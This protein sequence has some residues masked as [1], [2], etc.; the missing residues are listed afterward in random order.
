MNKRTLFG[1]TVG[2]SFSA[3]AIAGWRLYQQ[4]PIERVPSQEGIEDPAAAL[5]YGRIMRFPHVALLRKYIARRG[6][7]V[8]RCGGRSWLWPGLPGDRAGAKRT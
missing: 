5:A 4:R 7:D 2:V 6:A 8:Y 3:L 1:M